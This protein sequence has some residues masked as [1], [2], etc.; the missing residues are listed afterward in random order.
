MNFDVDITEIIVRAV[1]SIVVILMGRHVIPWL[2]L[3]FVSGWVAEAVKA[4]EQVH[5]ESGSGGIK[6]DE[7]LTFLSETLNHYKIHITPKELDTLIESAVKKLSLEAKSSN[8]TVVETK[9]NK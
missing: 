4:A 2:K 7:V 1:I 6:K 5:K 3:H 9:E 8:V